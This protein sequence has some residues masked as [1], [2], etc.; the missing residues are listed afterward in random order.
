MKFNKKMISKPQ[1]FRSISLS[2]PSIN[3]QTAVSN[4]LTTADKDI[5]LLEDKLKRFKEQKRGAGVVD[6]GRRGGFYPRKYRE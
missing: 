1:A 5:A 4:I 6:R 3:E 2:I